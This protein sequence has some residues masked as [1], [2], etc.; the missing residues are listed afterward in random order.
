[1][2]T[3]SHTDLLGSKRR[4][5]KTSLILDDGVGVAE[6]MAGGKSGI[7]TATQIVKCVNHHAVLVAFLQKVSNDA[8]S[9]LEFLRAH[10]AIETYKI[11]QP[12]SSSVSDAK[13]L[14][15]KVKT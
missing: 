15:A 1:M 9:L 14:L 10:D 7:E 12:L 13:A 4:D 5:G 6:T 11:R 8:E 2:A 3:Y